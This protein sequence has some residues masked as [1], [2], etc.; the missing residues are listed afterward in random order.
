[1]PTVAYLYLPGYES[2]S[3]VRSGATHGSLLLVLLWVG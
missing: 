1:L 3:R 2:I